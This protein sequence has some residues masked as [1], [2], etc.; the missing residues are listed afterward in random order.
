MIKATIY[1][2]KAEVLGSIVLIIVIII[3]YKQNKLTNSNEYVNFVNDVIQTLAMQ[4]LADS[5]FSGYS[6]SP[7]RL[8]ERPWRLGFVR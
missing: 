5:F 6:K 7:R 2:S 1:E 8:G 3:N 4:L